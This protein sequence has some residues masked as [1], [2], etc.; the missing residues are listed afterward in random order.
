MHPVMDHIGL[1]RIGQQ[2]LIQGSLSLVEAAEPLEQA[3][4]L[5]AKRNTHI[6]GLDRPAPG[7]QRFIRLAACFEEQAKIDGGGMQVR[8]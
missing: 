5:N 4:T 7:R 2:N 8:P 6:V 1:R 3:P